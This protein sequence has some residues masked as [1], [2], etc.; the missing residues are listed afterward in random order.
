ME[1]SFFYQLTINQCNNQENSEAVIL[2][3]LGSETG[4]HNAVQG[5]ISHESQR[6]DDQNF[7]DGCGQSVDEKE[8]ENLL[9]NV[10]GCGHIGLVVEGADV[11]QKL[12]DVHKNSPQNF[13]LVVFD[14]VI[15]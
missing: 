11:F 4:G 2:D 6:D 8:R 7:A 14:T 13:S 12:F 5:I 3:K 10:E 1:G 15:V 9:Y